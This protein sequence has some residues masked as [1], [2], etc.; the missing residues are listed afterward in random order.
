MTT[1]PLRLYDRSRVVT[2][3]RCPR[4]R[5]WQYEFNGR[6]IVSDSTSLE[7]HM[8]TAVHDALAAIASEYQAT[9]KVDIDAIAT[10][11]SRGMYDSL[12][13]FAVDENEAEGR[14]FAAE[15][16]A[17]VEGLVR[18]FYA[19]VWPTLTAAYPVILAIEQ[20][21]TYPQPDGLCFMAK[22]DLVVMDESE[23]VWYVEY[24]TTSS[25]KPS[26]VQSWQTAV[27]LHSTIRA[28]EA[29]IGRD[30]T[31]VHVQGLYKGYESYGKQ[32]SPFCYAYVKDAA[33]PFTAERVEYEYK[34][35]FRRQPTW[36]RPGGV[37]AWVA[38]MPAN[39]LADQFPQAPPIFIKD[40][41]V[42][43]FFRQ[44]SRR[45]QEIAWAV[46]ELAN[47]AAEMPSTGHTTESLMDATFRQHFDQCVPAWGR[48]CSY[49][50]LCH[51]HVED[52]LTAGY[53]WR[54]PHHTPELEL[55][56]NEGG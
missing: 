55:M 46:G 47:I 11:A 50:M 34:P 14:T 17:L 45:E 4:A 15:Q 22:P 26:W 16:A 28:I 38:G 10:T 42:E 33:P 24:K 9:G 32:N 20:E 6:G 29:T 27:Q 54:E 18:G 30:V 2:D 21:M 39:M 13:Q 7:L 52:P 25:K 31:G 51:G 48:P 43:A 41:L 3:W 12:M 1:A 44:T 19:H 40:D 37:A 8:G 35:G 53:C 23:A 49:R 56:S 36:E 5:Y